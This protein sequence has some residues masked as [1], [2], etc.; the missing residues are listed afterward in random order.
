MVSTR[1]SLYLVVI[2]LPL[3]YPSSVYRSFSVRECLINQLK[4]T[5]IT[6]RDQ[7]PRHGFEG[8]RR[9]RNRKWQAAVFGRGAA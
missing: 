2:Q 7:L 1:T 9:G 5:T 8:G 6:E 4:K 3:A